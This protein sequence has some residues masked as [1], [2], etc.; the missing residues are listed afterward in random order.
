LIENAILSGLIGNEDYTRRVIPFVKP[1]YFDDLN[2]RM[3]FSDIHLYVEKYNGLPTKEALRI[4]TDDRKD[5]NDEQHK[6]LTNIIN[7]LEYDSK[8]DQDW[9]A[10]QTE[11]FC[12]DKAIYN[13]VRKSILVL[14]GQE[15]ELDKGSIP[16]LLSDALGVSF[17]GHIGHDFLDM[18]DSRF[19]Y[20]HT[21]EDKVPFDLDFFN[22]I[23]KGGL[24]RKSLSIAL[25]GCVHPETMISVR[26][27]A[28]SS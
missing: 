27:R 7:S 20:Y 8:T 4:T 18:G 9:L 28:V 22:R 23:T 15:K 19:E 6:T 13:A 5:I 11:K 10:D 24:S 26:T 12:Q 25:A 14:D 1:E 21:N 2:Y 3:L 17:D 16:Q